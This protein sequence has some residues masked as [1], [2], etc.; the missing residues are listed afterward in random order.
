MIF[1]YQA[2]NDQGKTVADF[3]DAPTESAAR[4]KIKSLGLYPVKIK[5]QDVSGDSSDTESSGQVKSF[6]SNLTRSFDMRF[7]SR[8]IGLFSRQLSTL[9]RAGLPLPTAIADIIDQIENVNFRNIIVDLREKLEEGSSFS[10]ALTQLGYKIKLLGVAV[11]HEGGVEQRV[12]PTLVPKNSPVSETDGVFNAVVIRADFVG[13][14]MLEGRGAGSHPTAS[15]VVGDV[16]DI[17][18]GNKRPVFGIPAKEL[19]PFKQAPQKAHEGGY[20]VALRLHDKPGAVA[21]VARILAD[22]KISIE[23]IVQRGTATG[24]E[25]RETAPFILI[26]HNTL[27]QSI[28][29]AIGKIEK[30]GH[31]AGH[32]RVIRIE[33]L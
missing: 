23:S 11:E 30:D 5:K 9:L 10:N 18:R 14:L 8:H 6:L 33:R 13:D 28:R 27:E 29:S 1:Q 24:E 3:I 17:A 21:A 31:V 4:Q 15:A 32:S 25:T 19:K 12:H 16:V 7:S 26:T 20:Y 22:E 2:L